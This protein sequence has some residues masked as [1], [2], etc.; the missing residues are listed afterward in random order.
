[1][2][3]CHGDSGAFHL[4]VN[5]ANVEN[6]EGESILFTTTSLAKPVENRLHTCSLCMALMALWCYFSNLS[7]ST[8]I[9]ESLQTGKA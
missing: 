6:G 2:K 8:T 3:C 4:I 1:M 7:L 5:N 9:L